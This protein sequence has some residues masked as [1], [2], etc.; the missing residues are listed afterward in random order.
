MDIALSL[1][2]AY[3][4]GSIP[5]AYLIGRLKGID[6]RKV[7][8]RN[9]GAFNVFRHAGLIAGI[10][11]L[12]ADIG[13]GALAIVIAKALCGEGLVAFIAG[14]TA[15][16]GHNWPVFLRF[17]GGRGVGVIIGV[18]LVLLPREIS[19]T[20]GLSAAVLFIT[21]NSIWCGVALFVPLPLLCWLFSEPISLLAYSMALPCLSGL[22]HWL[23][24]RH[25]LPEAQKEA[26][27]FWI[28]PEASRER[29][30]TSQTR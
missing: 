10:A 13:K 1:I 8:D 7:G 4:L 12:V 17:R 29:R 6:I 11:T 18:L 5:F 2:L 16:A 20:L 28:A 27:M 3:F 24:T 15:V 22:A 23:T 21:R 14:G 26:E 19:I 9:V 25:L 30:D